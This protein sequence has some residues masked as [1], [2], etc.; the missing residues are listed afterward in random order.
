[1]TRTLLLVGLCCLAACSSSEPV[2]V[3]EPHALIVA[4]VTPPVVREAARTQAQAKRYVETRPD[5][6]SAELIRMLELSEAM[7]RAVHRV[8]AHRSAANVRAVRQAIDA[9]RGFMR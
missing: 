6:S 1:M 8:Q 3:P 4:P 9:L 2:V 5:L 7:R